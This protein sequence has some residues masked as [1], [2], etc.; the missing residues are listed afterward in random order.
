MNSFQSKLSIFLGLIIV[1]FSI[2]DNVKSKLIFLQIVAVYVISQ[3]ID[4]LVVGNCILS[5]WIGLIIPIVA[6]LLTLL[7]RFCLLYTS[8]SP[9]DGLLSRMPSSA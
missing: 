3:N 7:N 9:R 2:I 4:C 6:F 8:P 1:L 5:S